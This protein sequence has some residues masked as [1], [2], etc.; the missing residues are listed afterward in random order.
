MRMRA[1]KHF[2]RSNTGGRGGNVFI[3]FKVGSQIMSRG[4]QLYKRLLDYVYS[5]NNQGKKPFQQQ[6][7]LKMLTMISQNKP[8]GSDIF[9]N[10]Y[11]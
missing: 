2:C 3:S 4:P 7:I 6:A 11:D 9:F 1:E 5:G 8:P 10:P